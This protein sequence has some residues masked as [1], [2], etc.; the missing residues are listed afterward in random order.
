MSDPQT[1]VMLEQAS[2]RVKEELSYRNRLLHLVKLQVDTPDLWKRSSTPE[3]SR[4]RLA[5]RVLH[6]AVENDTDMF[7]ELTRG[8]IYDD[9]IRW[10]KFPDSEKERQSK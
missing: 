5:L 2:A 8:T 1:T 9:Q 6:A 7:L 4:L 3:E 10:E